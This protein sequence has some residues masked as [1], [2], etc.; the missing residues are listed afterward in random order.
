MIYSVIQAAG[1]PFTLSSL[2]LLLCN[3]PAVAPDM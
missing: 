1:A 2:S 3:V